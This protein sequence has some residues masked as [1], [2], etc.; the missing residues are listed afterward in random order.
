MHPLGVW[1][2]YC[3]W[4]VLV[5]FGFGLCSAWSQEAPEP[6]QQPPTQEPVQAPV[7][8]GDQTLFS[9]RSRLYS[10]SPEERAR[11]ISERLNR[12]YRDNTISPDSIQVQ[13]QEGTIEII[14]GDLVIMAVT[15]SDAQAAGMTRMALAQQYAQT[16]RDTV[17]QLR[18][19]FN[20]RVLALGL[21]WS[22]LT[23]AIFF[24][25]IFGL[26]KLIPRLVKKLHSWRGTRIRSIRIQRLE[27]LP[28]HR[29]T[30]LLIG[31]LKLAHVFLLLALTYFYISLV[32]NFFPWTRGY[33]RVLFNYVLQP[34][35]FVVS[36]IAEYLP[37]LFF[38]LVII[39]VTYYM[40]K[41][42]KFFFREV[43]RGTL[44]FP[45]FYPEWAMP[46]Y[47]ISRILIIAF[48]AVV[49]FPYLPGSRSPAF[50]G[51]S[52]FLG[53]L[54]SLGS[55]SAIANMVAGTVLTYTCA[56]QIG[57]RVKIGEAQGDV[58]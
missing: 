49:M 39:V 28:A 40:M 31:L 15:E 2:S 13:E 47:K 43:D 5:L 14:A 24:A 54:F 18:A 37:N 34:V 16:I 26:G 8:I 25:I 22:S 50:Q 36:A 20:W 12:L 19:D 48:A 41:V 29:L 53:L 46:T 3:I 4:I 35:Q 30:G 45:G 1:R 52:I 6:E 56:F 58:M 9:V 42:V 33:A 17:A 57:D 27:L 38:V 10:F 51:I 11:A 55:T 44:E 23:T 21:L 7:V 32:F